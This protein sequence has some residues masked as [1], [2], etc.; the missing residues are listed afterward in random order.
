MITPSPAELLASLRAARPLVQNITN[1]VVTN[2]TANVLLA[3]GA[4]PAMVDAAEEAADFVRISGAL[5]VNTGTLNAR[6]VASMKLAA[7]AA[8]EAG[9]PWVLDPVGAGATAYR[10]QTAL[11]LLALRPSVV[12]GNAGEI[13]ALA[14]AHDASQKGVDSGASAD[15]AVGAG[16][17]LLR[18]FGCVAAIT[19]E[20]DQ[21][22]GPSGVTAVTGGHARIQQVTGTGCATTAIVGAFLAI[23][24]PE[25][26]ALAGLT[27][28]KRATERAMSGNPGPG[29]LAVQ[30][31][32]ALDAIAPADL[33]AVDTRQ[34]R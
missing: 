8:A 33:R 28:M 13:L 27:L 6:T 9:V 30:L 10:T 12:R 25:A 20:T 5:V 29:T 7:E 2:F 22:V 26:A 3:L 4:S 14:G 11:E 15:A 34:D 32:D 21:I 31:L 16:Q 17:M 23:A 19:G 18:D 1:T 24:R